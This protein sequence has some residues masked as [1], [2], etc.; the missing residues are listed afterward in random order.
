[1]LKVRE[2]EQWLEDG[3]E[4]PATYYVN[5]MNGLTGNLAKDWKNGIDG[6]RA[7]MAEDCKNAAK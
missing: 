2:A 1:V 4:D 6:I 7:Q 5:T 3:Q